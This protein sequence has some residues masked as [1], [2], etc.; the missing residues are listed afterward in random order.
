MQHA[1]LVRA[2]AREVADDDEVLAVHDAGELADPSGE[3]ARRGLQA[4]L[5]LTALHGG[6][7]DAQVVVEHVPAEKPRPRLDAALVKQ[8]VGEKALEHEFELPGLSGFLNLPAHR[9][10][11]LLVARK[12]P[13]D[14]GEQ[15]PHVDR[16]LLGP[17]DVEVSVAPSGRRLAHAD[18]GRDAACVGTCG[19][20][21][22]LRDVDGPLLGHEG[23]GVGARA[24]R[25]TGRQVTRE[26]ERGE[27]VSEDL[28]VQPHG[29]S[30]VEW[31]KVFH[32]RSVIAALWWGC[33]GVRFIEFYPLR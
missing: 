33:L 7:R 27:L 26:L 19:Q 31:Y 2:G 11:P 4:L 9:A 6:D 22:R 8:L 25:R 28:E 23:E 17:E 32:H 5:A 29:V 15:R 24:R 14:A 20:L 1:V 3:R 10:L 21:A 12:G 13:R 16:T 18:D 30:I